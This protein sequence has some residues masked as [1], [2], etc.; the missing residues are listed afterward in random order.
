MP[1]FSVFYV[2]ARQDIDGQPW[3][4]IGAS[5]DGRRDGWLPANAVSDWKQSLVLKFTERSGRAPVMFVR[6]A[7]AL[8]QLLAEPARAREALREALK[9]T[10]HNVVAVEPGGSAVPQDQ[11]YLLPI[12]DSEETFDAN[13]QPLQ[14]LNVA[15]I[16]PGSACLLYTSPS[17]R[18]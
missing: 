12:F 18:D 8:E 11:F 10:G 7:S 6:D 2:Y 3:L 15:S 5:T 13:G 9:G 1:A 14:L 4:Q 16:D 17:P